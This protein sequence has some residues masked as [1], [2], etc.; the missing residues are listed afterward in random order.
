MVE[1]S[2]CLRRETFDSFA[3][4]PRGRLRVVRAALCTRLPSRALQGAGHSAHSAGWE[5]SHLATQIKIQVLWSAR[6]R[7]PHRFL[8]SLKQGHSSLT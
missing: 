4:S 2:V 6:K 8:G 7:E 1:P 5:G 3:W